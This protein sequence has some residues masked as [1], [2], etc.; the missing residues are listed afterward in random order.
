MSEEPIAPEI[1]GMLEEYTENRSV[2]AVAGSTPLD[3]E[4][5]VLAF[6]ENF[7]AQFFRHEMKVYITS[8]SAVSSR[9]AGVLRRRTPA[10]EEQRRLIRDFQH[11]CKVHPDL[12][13]E[14]YGGGGDDRAE[15]FLSQLPDMLRHIETW[16]SAAGYG[17]TAERAGRTIEIY[18]RFLDEEPSSDG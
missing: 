16:A 2:S 12:V 10:S 17:R 7:Y 3:P 11:L 5:S 1:F 14:T 8:V 4:S 9:R 18:N 13:G 15:F 6:S